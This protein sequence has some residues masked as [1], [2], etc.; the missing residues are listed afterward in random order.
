MLIA[1]RTALAAPQAK[2]VQPQAAGTPRTTSSVRSR[3]YAPHFSITPES[4]AET[5]LGATGGAA[6]S[7]GGNGARPIL[8]PKPAKASTSSAGATVGG[9]EVAAPGIWNGPSP[10]PTRGKSVERQDAPA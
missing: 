9:K 6:G 8:V 5:W 3:P 4:R 7:Q 1:P 10:A 2:S